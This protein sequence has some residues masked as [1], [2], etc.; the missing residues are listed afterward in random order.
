MEGQAKDVFSAADSAGGS[1]SY[2]P[3]L[4]L[5]VLFAAMY[6]LFVRPNKRRRQQ[7]EQMQSALGVGD[8]VLT[9]GGLFGVVR[10]FTDD[11]V[12]LE[13]APGV[14]NQYSRAAIGQVVNAAA[15]PDD[16]LAGN[17]ADKV[18]DTD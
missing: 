18:I 15:K 7:V 17:S 3:I 6:F 16:P 8:E 2:A 5:L 12:I 14:T 4:M 13:V 9:V 1:G 11:R 10:G